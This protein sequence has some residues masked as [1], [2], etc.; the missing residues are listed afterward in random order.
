MIELQDCLGRMFTKAQLP[1]ELQLYAQTL[2]AMKEEKENYV[3]IVVG[4]QLI[5]KDTNCQ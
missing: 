4:K 3:A 5:K 2:P 1:A